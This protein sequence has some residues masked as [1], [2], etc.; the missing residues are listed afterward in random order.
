MGDSAKATFQE[1]SNKIAPLML[2]I[3]QQLVESFKPIAKTIGDIA[4][5][6]NEWAKANPTI[7]N[8]AVAIA[9][10]TSAV[11]TLSGTFL[12]ML[13]AIKL[14]TGSVLREFGLMLKG[15]TADT[16]AAT[17]ATN[18]YNASL[19]GLSSTMKKVKGAGAAGMLNGVA[20]PKIKMIDGKDSGGIKALLA[21]LLGLQAG[22]RGAI[23][24]IA[25]FGAQIATKI[26]LV[27]LIAATIGML[28][29]FVTG[30]IKVFQKANGEVKKSESIWDSLWGSIGQ[31]AKIIGGLLEAVF[32]GMQYL[33]VLFGALVLA[34]G[35]A[36]KSVVDFVT[37]LTPVKAAIEAAGQA[38]EWLGGVF[39]WIG[40]ELQRINDEA[41]VNLGE[42]SDAV[43]RASEADAA[44][45]Q[46]RYEVWKKGND[47]LLETQRQA[48]EQALAEEAAALAAEARA[49]EQHA[50]AM[51]EAAMKGIYI[52]TTMVMDKLVDYAE[53]EG[54]MVPQ[55]FAS[56]ILGEDTKNMIDLFEASIST[57][58]EQMAS[59]DS[60]IAK[61][62][63]Q[64]SLNMVDQF[65]KEGKEQVPPATYALVG[66]MES[67]LASKD[68]DIRELGTDVMAWLTDDMAAYGANATPIAIGE[69]L[70]QV[71]T[72]LNSSK[73]DL[74]NQ[75][76]DLM[77]YLMSG[78]ASQPGLS[79]MI[80]AQLTEMSALMAGGNI[81]AAKT[82]YNL[83]LNWMS[84]QYQAFDANVQ[85]IRARIAAL[86]ALLGATTSYQ[87]GIAIS[88]QIIDLE[89]ILD[90]A[91]GIKAGGKVKVT[92]PT[93]TGGGGGSSGRSGGGA[94][95]ERN[96]LQEALTV[97]QNG[98]ELAEALKE[99][100]GTNLKA[101]VKKAMGGVASAMKLAM[102]IT[103]KY[104]KGF[105]TKQMQK[106]ADFASAIS[107]VASA[108][109]ASVEAFNKVRAYKN[110]NNKQFKVLVDDVHYAVAV[111]AKEGKK[112]KGKSLGQAQVFAEVAETIAGTMGDAA[113]SLTKVA[114][115][116]NV[117]NDTFKTLAKDI[118]AAVL[119]MIAATK[120][121]KQSLVDAAAEFSEGAGSVIDVI[122][123]AF[124]TFVKLNA[125]VAPLPGV[126]EGIVDTTVVAVGLMIDAMGKFSL[127]SDQIEKITAFSEMTSAVV[128][129]VSDT[130]DAFEKTIQFV[131]QFRETIN[132][133]KVFSWIAYSVAE[134]KKIAD[135]YSSETITK[136]G[137]L[138][139]AVAGIAEAI[140][141]FFNIGKDASQDPDTLGAL[142]QQALGAVLTVVADFVSAF[143]QAGADMIQNFADGMRSQE[144]YLAAEVQRIEAILGGGFAPTQVSI[145]STSPNLT[146]THIVKDP[147]GALANADTEQVAAMLSG[148]TF[149]KNLYSAA[150]TQ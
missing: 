32:H 149:I 80:A 49:I 109:D 22:F 123:N 8:F 134:M 142:V 14:L 16:V 131:D 133:E 127:S 34:V 124:E 18:T 81:E 78:F 29:G 23:T 43:Q 38:L 44:R 4:L 117:A 120:G 46:G 5:K 17:V 61:A 13:G 33:G 15:N 28:V 91:E 126:L 140:D 72:L 147:D 10:V 92:Q 104:A 26:P 148:S 75:G 9:A 41:Q 12:L 146:I 113:E 150:N 118:T 84:G 106:V 19:I 59:G 93:T 69:I 95:A 52:P 31:V 89:R 11:A 103:Y 42:T 1:L 74:Q 87:G 90:L 37:N 73:P 136:I 116:K 99:L 108:I 145:T 3:G 45:W 112:F 121:V 53:S 36:I 143:H 79:P 135:V 88:K 65:Y 47:A 102:Q 138:A 40:D 82:G 139:T 137:S 130:Y 63:R 122:G 70:N 94:A 55:A 85:G 141:K 6:I 57:S 129:A 125:Y 86:K 97:A 51:E 144:G 115:Y 20:V 25:Q 114:G 24:A 48:N 71:N 98:V 60:K 76:A 119:A 66:F 2:R 110:V 35:G 50:Q 39:K 58:L 105:S 132:F 128:T 30:F 67:A 83:M 96:P 7:F 68:K 27:A 100:E 56:G 21:N 77:A 62:G 54:K 111:M 107:E 101:L 64:A